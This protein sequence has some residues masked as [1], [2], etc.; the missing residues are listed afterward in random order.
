MLHGAAASHEPQP[1]D[2]DV[3]VVRG[4]IPDFGSE[5]VYDATFVETR[6]TANEY[7]VYKAQQEEKKAK[8][9][10][11]MRNVVAMQGT[12]RYKD[13]PQFQNPGPKELAASLQSVSPGWMQV[14]KADLRP[15]I[16]S[17]LPP[18]DLSAEKLVQYTEKARQVGLQ[19]TQ[20]ETIRG[21]ISTMPINMRDQFFAEHPRF[22]NPE[23]LVPCMW[24]EDK[25]TLLCVRKE[26]FDKT[27]FT[28]S[29]HAAQSEAEAQWIR[30]VKL[31][32]GFCKTIVELQA[33]ASMK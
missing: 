6:M 15:Y 30:A 26:L 28:L 21:M 13:V 19:T 25:M 31:H 9:L 32:N 29:R 22:F 3:L 17:G 2:R 33:F 8:C 24:L 10:A 14:S 23:P 18:Q 4:I 11:Q 7:G 27:M 5:N 12:D 20:D 16:P 1:D